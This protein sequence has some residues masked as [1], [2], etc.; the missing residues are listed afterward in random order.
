M[1]LEL[2]GS[3][4]HIVY[5]VDSSADDTVY[6]GVLNNPSLFEGKVSVEGQVESQ[7]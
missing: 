2:L 1:S 3:V 4:S 5:L 6:D 7:S